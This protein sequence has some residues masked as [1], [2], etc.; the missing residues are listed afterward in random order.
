MRLVITVNLASMSYL[1]NQNDEALVLKVINGAV[2]AH[3][4]AVETI[5]S[6]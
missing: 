5:H 6:G 4:D 2:I 1:D 3:A